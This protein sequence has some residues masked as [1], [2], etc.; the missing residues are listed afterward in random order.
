MRPQASEGE[1]QH[2]IFCGPVVSVKDTSICIVDGTGRIVHLAVLLALY[3]Q[4]PWPTRKGLCSSSHLPGRERAN[5]K[6][7]MSL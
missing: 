7:E 6:D 2:G 3:R 5:F 1:A 4:Q